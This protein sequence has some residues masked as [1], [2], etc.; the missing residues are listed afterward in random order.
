MRN[1]RG[2]LHNLYEVFPD[3]GNVDFL[4]VV[5]ILR[6]TQF[7][8]SICPDHLPSHPD[9]PGCFQA[10]AIPFGYFQGLIRVVNNEV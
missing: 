4:E 7:S 8:G 9:D 3:E 10:F 1:I 5:R 2:G 6:V